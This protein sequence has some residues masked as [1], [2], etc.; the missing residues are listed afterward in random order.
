METPPTP[1]CLGVDDW[2][3]KKG[4]TYGTLLCD[5]ERQQVIELWEGRDGDP[6]AKWLQDIRSQNHHAR[7]GQRLC[8]RARKGA[9]QATQV[10]DRFHLR[11]NLSK[12][13][14]TLFEQQPQVLKLPITC[15]NYFI[16]DGHLV[17]RRD[18]DAG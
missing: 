1:R 11:Q 14:R 10:A 12:A 2:A 7:P 8:G 17:V 9:P 15:A 13:L 5:L 4:H 18:S 3:L 6:L 16:S